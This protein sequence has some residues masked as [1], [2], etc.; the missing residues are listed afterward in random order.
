MRRLVKLS[1]W[2]AGGLA[3]SLL[4]AGPVHA[5]TSTEGSRQEAQS[6][7]RR[8]PN[9]ASVFASD[10]GL[11]LTF[12]KPDKT[13]DFEAVL[14]RLRDALK[15]SHKP[16]RKRQ[17]RGWKVLRAAEPA[18]NGSVLYVS[19]IDPTVKGQDYSVSK[20]L[21]ESFPA[22]VEKLSKQFTDTFAVP[23]SIVGLDLLSAL[24]QR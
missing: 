13:A 17:A 20:I 14:A 8:P 3:F 16:D 5:Q 4:L 24:G 12:V 1:L 9:S 7:E 22:E 6:A 11:V 18:T 23:Q 21:A 15:K 19:I 2:A 10:A